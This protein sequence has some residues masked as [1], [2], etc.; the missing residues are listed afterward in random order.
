MR[1][2][3]FISSTV[4]SSLMFS[5]IFPV[6]AEHPDI[7]DVPGPGGSGPRGIYET[8]RASESGQIR[9]D[10]PVRFDTPEMIQERATGNDAPGRQQKSTKPSKKKTPITDERDEIETRPETKTPIF[11]ETVKPARNEMP[12]KKA[13]PDRK[14]AVNPQSSHQKR[15]EMLKKAQTDRTR[16]QKEKEKEIDRSVSK[17]NPRPQQSEETQLPEKKTAAVD[18]QNSILEKKSPAVEKNSVAANSSGTNN[19]PRTSSATGLPSRLEPTPKGRY[20]YRTPDFYRGIYLNNAVPR[21]PDIYKKLLERAHAHGINTLVVDVQ[22]SMPPIEFVK[23]ARESGFY[24]VARVVVFEGGLKVFP[25]PMNHIAGV[26]DS[27]EG[28]AKNGFMEVQLDYIRFADYSQSIGLSLEKRYNVIAGILKMATDRIRPHGVRIGADIFGR[29]AFNRDDIIGQ[30]LE[31]FAAHL[32]TIYPMLYPSHF[33]GEPSRINDPY[34]TILMGTKNSVERIGKESKVVAYIQGFPMSVQG[35][36]LTYVEYIRRQIQAS[37]EAGG[38][39]YVV[40]NALNDYT[41]LFQAI[42][43][44]EKTRRGSGLVSNP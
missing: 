13:G 4:I 20:K 16:P 30:K 39:G 18:K 6:V 41:A 5:G 43:A 35:T 28:A 37:E 9:D 19:I 17:K 36:G 38:S 44:H 42:S 14:E 3:V 15:Q 25:P 1:P 10:L 33:Y 24:L 32:D 34:T 23:L 8:L 2:S 22:P 21:R 40:W 7:P 29:I 31:L 11:E 26:L 12:E 27:A